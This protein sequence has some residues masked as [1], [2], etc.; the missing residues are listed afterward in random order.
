MLK[1]GC[2]L[3]KKIILTLVFVF[4]SLS[5]QAFDGSRP[6]SF[7][8]ENQDITSALSALAREQNLA[9]HFTPNVVG[10]IS[11]R[12]E[13][14]PAAHFLE[15]MREAFGI[16]WY[17]IS[18]LIY[19]YNQSETQRAFISTK[20]IPSNELI[21]MLE[22][23]DVISENLP[24]EYMPNSDML[25]VSGPLTYI[26]QVQGA[27]AAFEQAQTSN[28][29]ME[30]FPLKFAWA[31]DISITSMDTQVTIPGVATI[32]RSMVNGT[33]MSPSTTV[34]LPSTVTS[35]G[36]T[37]LAALGQQSSAAAPSVAASSD[38][39]E[40][41]NIIAD[42]RVNSVI[43]T[44]AAYRMSYY[45]EVIADLDK[46]VELV[47]IHAAIVDI[48]SGFSRNLGVNFQGNMSTNAEG[49]NGIGGSTSGAPTT[50]IVP[51]IAG[52]ILTGG[53]SSTIYSLGTEF[54]IAQ[55]EAL[56]ANN[57]ARVLGKPSVLTMDNVQATLEN[58]STYYIEV[59]GTD[60]ADLFKV[61]AGTILKVTPHII[62]GDN[63]N[64]SIKLV[65]NVQDNQGDDGSQAV[66]ALPPIRQT[67]I[68]TQAIVNEGE[69]LLIG[70]YFYEQ[71][72]E[73][74]SGV[75]Y[76]KDIPLLG[77]LFKSSSKTTNT[78]ERLILIT[79]RIVRHNASYEVPE[80]VKEAEFS[81]SPIQPNYSVKTPVNKPSSSGCSKQPS[82]E[83]EI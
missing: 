78:L 71:V 34:Q 41:V 20:I 82:P 54:F 5:A 30:V 77:N 59:A 22:N 50:S 72:S 45:R 16:G 14:I 55:V 74:D 11:G 40:G 56:Q 65:V 28:F 32:L 17:S 23:S 49:N 1:K 51:P 48:D 52:E 79:P 19:Y 15:T 43:I 27:I 29:V 80:R 73:E 7:Y 3:F 39:A 21:D 18:D 6:F 4:S 9:P 8:A 2:I 61:E 75:P 62:T 67:K 76:L 68:N 58:T 60:V 46:P 69:S 25:V 12:F 36:G 64:S 13:N 33:Q 81:R 42:P 38:K 47:E 10:T 24:L 70:G 57:N 44:D 66:G 37:G 83:E 35:L 63:G 31:D 53:L 26:Q